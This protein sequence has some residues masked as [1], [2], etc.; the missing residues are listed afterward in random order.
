MKNTSIG[1]HKSFSG[2]IKYLISYLELNLIPG[3]LNQKWKQYFNL[4]NILMTLLSHLFVKP[5]VINFP[6]YYGKE[7]SF[8][9]YNS[10]S[11]RQTLIVNSLKFLLLI[12]KQQF[13]QLF[14]VKSC[15]STNVLFMLGKQFIYRL[16]HLNYLLKFL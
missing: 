5:Q 12:E 1:Y 3:T 10:V 13:I 6:K 14:I 8:L 9:E 15:Y 11:E 2:V 7:G 4:L 16:R